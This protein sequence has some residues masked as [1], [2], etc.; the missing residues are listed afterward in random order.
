MKKYFGRVYK[1]QNDVD[2]LVYIGS[3]IQ[4]L[5]MR[6]GGHRSDCRKEKN[7]NHKAYKH[8][9]SIGIEHFKIVLIENM[10]NCTKEE[11]RAKEDY[12]IKQFNSVKNG[13]NGCYSYGEKCE[14]GKRRSYC[15]PCGGSQIC[16]HGRQR[17]KCEPCGGASICE[18][19]KVRNYCKTCGG[20][21]ICEHGRQKHKCKPCG[22]AS[23][24]EHG[25][26]RHQCKT[27]KGSSVC[28]HGKR[29]YQCKICKGSSI[30]EHK[31]RKNYC[32]IC[33]PHKCE[34][35]NKIFGGAQNLKRHLKS[36]AHIK[37]EKLLNLK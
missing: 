2:D 3:T 13:L 20:S 15:K 7:K 8:M 31:I 21:Q 18:H 6:M 27:C 36:K 28:E 1:I 23:I 32:K 5:A 37:K 29:R 24:C 12:Y 17:H 34:I 30:C 25:R 19:G 4:T 9:R 11:L 14:H 16:E 26:Q 35:C 10:E 22:G 33:N